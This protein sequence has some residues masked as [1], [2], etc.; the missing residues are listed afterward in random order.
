M[1]NAQPRAT[2]T[3]KNK[4]WLTTRFHV[5]IWLNVTESETDAGSFDIDETQLDADLRDIHRYILSRLRPGDSS[6]YR[7]CRTAS[8]SEVHAL[9]ETTSKEISNSSDA[10]KVSRLRTLEVLT[11]I[12]NACDSIF[13]FFL[14]LAF[15]GPT[16]SKYYGAIHSLIMVCLP[17][18]YNVDS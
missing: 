17:E 5:F 7:N 1:A 9:V 3:P 18:Q 16:V 10:K 12:V 4:R 11:D 8:R 14:P 15:D 2:G 6:A 13:Q